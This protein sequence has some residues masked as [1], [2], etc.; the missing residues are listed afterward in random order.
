[1]SPMAIASRGTLSVTL[2]QRRRLMSRSSASSSAIAASAGS[3]AM[4]QIGQLP[5]PSRT[6]SGCMGHSHV[7]LG[8]VGLPG[9]GWAPSARSSFLGA[10]ACASGAACA[11]TS[12][13]FGRVGAFSSR[14]RRGS[15]TNFA[16]QPA[17]QNTYSRASC[18]CRCAVSDLGII[19]HT[20]SLSAGGCAPRSRS[21]PV[22]RGASGCCSCSLIAVPSLRRMPAAR[23]AA[24]AIVVT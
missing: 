14:Y 17:L 22:A 10:V 19:P 15:A 3:S 23:H 12:S 2:S 24:H 20:G 11:I 4:P 13:A 6:I 21:V 1:M 16:L 8:P 18:T 5:G 7:L 9:C